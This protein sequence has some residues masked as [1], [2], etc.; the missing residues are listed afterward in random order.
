METPYGTDD[1]MLTVKQATGLLQVDYKSVLQWVYRDF[2]P[3][4]HYLPAGNKKQVRI[5]KGDL[6][7]WVD[8]NWTKVE[9]QS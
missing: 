1:Q 9:R 4:P 3:I 8:R 5:R 7:A 6:M 2:D